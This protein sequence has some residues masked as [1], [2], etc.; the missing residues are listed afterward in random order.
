MVRPDG[1]S[2]SLRSSNGLAAFRYH[3]DGRRPKAH[4]QDLWH[5]WPQFGSARFRAVLARAVAREPAVHYLRT[6]AGM[7]LRLA[8]ADLGRNDLR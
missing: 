6:Q 8:L 4:A 5:G 3:R 2:D 7:G 1:E